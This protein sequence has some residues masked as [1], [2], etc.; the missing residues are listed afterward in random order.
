MRNTNIKIDIGLIPSSR[1]AFPVVVEVVVIALVVDELVVLPVVVEVV[2][3]ALVVDELVVGTTALQ[4]F[5]EPVSLQSDMKAD[6][7]QREP[8]D[9]TQ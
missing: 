4:L 7:K 2:S 5:Q 8:V 6:W 9:V 1:M 3:I